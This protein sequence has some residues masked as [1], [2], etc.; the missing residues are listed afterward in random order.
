VADSAAPAVNL[1]LL[2]RL[3]APPDDA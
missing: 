2:H 1:W 3:A